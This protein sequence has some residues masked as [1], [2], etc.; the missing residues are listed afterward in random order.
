VGVQ[1]VHRALAIE[2]QEEVGVHESSANT[3]Q[4]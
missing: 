2:E 4:H 3:S 1:K